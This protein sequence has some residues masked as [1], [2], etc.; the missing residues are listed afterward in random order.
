MILRISNV[1]PMPAT[2]RPATSPSPL[3][4]WGNCTGGGHVGD[5]VLGAAAGKP[6]TVH[7]AVPPFGMVKGKMPGWSPDLNVVGSGP[8]KLT[9]VMLLLTPLAITTLP[10]R[11]LK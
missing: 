11:L 5:E 2:R 9:G 4:S 3:P 6:F 10:G 7:V 1:P 8:S